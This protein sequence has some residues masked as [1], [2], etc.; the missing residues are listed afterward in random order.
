M[1]ITTDIIVTYDDRDQE[2]FKHTVD[3]DDQIPV[4]E[5]EKEWITSIVKEVYYPKEISKL[6][7][8]VYDPNPEI[9]HILKR[10][11]GKYYFQPDQRCKLIGEICEE[12]PFVAKDTLS[13]REW[14]DKW[15]NKQH[16]ERLKKWK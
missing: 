7:L 6:S 14:E 16:K 4:Y 1:K 3:I 11:N 2:F 15:N 10:T 12:Y 8:M 9:L 5:L 13:F